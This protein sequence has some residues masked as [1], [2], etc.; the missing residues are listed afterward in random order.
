MLSTHLK[1]RSTGSSTEPI[2]FSVQGIVDKIYD[3]LGI[4]ITQQS[5]VMPTIHYDISEDKLLQVLKTFFRSTNNENETISVHVYKNE[6][7]YIK[8]VSNEGTMAVIPARNSAFSGHALQISWQKENSNIQ[9]VYEFNNDNSLKLV[10]WIFTLD[11]AKAWVK[12]GVMP[13]N[14]KEDEVSYLIS[15][16]IEGVGGILRTNY[17]VSYNIA[18]DDAAAILSVL[19]K[20]DTTQMDFVKARAI[21]NQISKITSIN[22]TFSLEIVA[23]SAHNFKCSYK[24]MCLNSFSVNING[25]H[26]FYIDED[27]YSVETLSGTEMSCKDGILK[28]RGKKEM[29]FSQFSALDSDIHNLRERYFNLFD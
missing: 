28:C 17:D 10:E 15:I 29:L 11:K 3:S 21:A 4:K 12:K 26:Y 22:S 25:T 18:E 13:R 19:C 6:N 20:Y 7:G 27:T 1:R 2:H 8:F 16:S 23:D 5:Q 24:N 14:C 9:S